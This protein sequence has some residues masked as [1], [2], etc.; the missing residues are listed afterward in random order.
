VTRPT[1][2]PRSAR[3]SAAIL[4]TCRPKP[5]RDTRHPR[6]RRDA[7]SGVR[8]RPPGA[9]RAR[10]V[11][12]LARADC[13]A[14]GGRRHSSPHTRW[15]AGA[16]TSGVN[17]PRHCTHRRRAI[18]CERPRN[19][20]PRRGSRS[21]RAPRRGSRGGVDHKRGERWITVRAPLK[22]RRIPSRPPRRGAGILMTPARVVR[23]R[24]PVDGFSRGPFVVARP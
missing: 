14:S 4:A 1:R 19:R 6:A 3:L 18:A 23:L 8:A 7:S 20:P 13:A 5:A 16:V 11:V 12:A 22:R 24:A 17:L 15:C 21:R 2:C 10:C 9:R